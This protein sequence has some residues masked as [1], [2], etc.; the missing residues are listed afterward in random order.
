MKMD[1]KRWL[2]LGGLLLQAC[3]HAPAGSTEGL[4]GEARVSLPRQVHACAWRNQAA[5]DDLQRTLAQVAS[6]RPER[7]PALVRAVAEPSSVRGGWEQELDRCRAGT[8]AA[9]D[10][11]ATAL[12]VVATG[13]QDRDGADAALLRPLAEAVAPSSADPASVALATR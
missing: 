13:G 7:A 10:A 9:C 8:G 4:L 2:L 3:A 12:I 6:L 1:A 5:C 11:A